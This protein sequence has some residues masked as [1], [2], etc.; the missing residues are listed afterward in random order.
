MTPAER[1]AR[2]YKLRRASGRCVKCGG[3]PE[4]GMVRCTSC[5]E[6]NRRGVDAFNERRD[7]EPRAGG[8]RAQLPP[9]TGDVPRCRCGLALPCESC[10]PTARDFAESR[11]DWT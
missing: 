2:L 3:W 11:R 9:A 8:P 10:L 6:S 7:A 4:P 1:M 5:L